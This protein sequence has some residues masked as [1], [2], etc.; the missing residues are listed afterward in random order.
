MPEPEISA[1]ESC[2]EAWAKAHEW[3]TDNEEYQALV[4]YDWYDRE[5]RENPSTVARI[6]SNLP[7]VRFCP[8]C[9]AKKKEVENE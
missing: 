2:C 3:K 4:H 7:P 9:G 6:G 8:W 1:V 5:Y